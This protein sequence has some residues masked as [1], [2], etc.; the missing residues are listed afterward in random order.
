MT[1][2]DCIHFGIC[3]KGFP[4][5]DGKGGGWCENFKDKSRIVELPCK[6]GDALY[7]IHGDKVY[8]GWE[9]VKI[10]A[11]MDEIWYVDDSDNCFTE[12]EIGKTVFITREEA[13]EALRKEREK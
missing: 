9:I 4:W 1:C 8:D 3:K 13:E 11:Y 12:E 2:K 10:E 5:A 6:L 7:R